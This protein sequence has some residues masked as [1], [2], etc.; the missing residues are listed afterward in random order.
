M[1][2]SVRSQWCRKS[3]AWLEKGAAP[4]RPREHI[5]RLEDGRAGGSFMGVSPLDASRG[6]SVDSC[7]GCPNLLERR[8]NNGLCRNYR[9]HHGT[10]IALQEREALNRAVLNSLAA[11]I[12]VLSSDGT[13]QAINEE[14]QRSVEVNGDPPACFLNTGLNYLEACK[15]A[16]DGG[17]SDA[18]KAIA[19]IQQV[20]AGKQ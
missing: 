7:T 2:P 1:V 12:A 11:N 17:S 18:E 9:R 14:W 13:I 4:W 15:R 8:R 20:L 5:Q 19:G 3:G 16:A 6:G 10:E